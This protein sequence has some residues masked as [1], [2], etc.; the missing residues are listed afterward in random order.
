MWLPDGE[1]EELVRTLRAETSK[2]LGEAFPGADFLGLDDAGAAQAQRIVLGVCDDED[3]NRVLRRQ[4]SL[5]ADGQKQLA[6][7]LCDEIFGMGVIQPHIDDRDPTAE[8]TSVNGPRVGFIT[9]SGNQV[10]R[11]DPHFASDE[12]L[13]AFIQR[14]VS[15]AGGRIDEASPYASVRLAN[16]CRLTAVLP[17]ITGCP[18]LTIRAPRARVRSVEDLADLNLF[19]APPERAAPARRERSLLASAPELARFLDAAVRGRLNIL[20]SGGTGT[21]KT[22]TL[23]GL[24]GAIPRDERVVTIETDPELMLEGD[25]L[26]N[27]VELFAQPRGRRGGLSATARESGAAAA[28]QQDPDWRGDGPR[29]RGHAQRHE[30]WSRRLDVYYSR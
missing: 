29:S 16:G 27:C 14:Q 12:E 5:G 24:C 28:T 11:M 18:R 21:G 10:E 30:F 2:R 17:P 1:L 23:R 3:R 8:E 13:R 22:T 4:P 9:R 7:R 25:V 15:R 19:S 20:V 6:E 26:E